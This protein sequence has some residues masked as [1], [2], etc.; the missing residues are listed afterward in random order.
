[1]YLYKAFG[2]HIASEVLIPQFI[3]AENHQA[4]VSIRFGLVEDVLRK[5]GR[6]ERAVQKSDK[7]IAFYF[8]KTGSFLVRNGN[9]IVVEPDSD[10]EDQLIRLPLIGIVM[11][12]LL[13]Q[14]GMF[15][16]HASAVS[17]NG[18]AVVFLG[19]KGAGKSTTAATLYKRGH[20]MISD[21]I[22][23]M[24][25]AETAVPLIESS[26]PNFKLMP[27]TAK[28][29]LGD[30][31]D[32]LSPVCTG[33]EKRFRPASD[34]FA[35][36]KQPLRAI[37]ALEDGASLSTTLLKPQEAVSTLIANTYLARYGK[38]LLQNNHAVK[39]LLECANIVN[40]IPVYRLERPRSFR[41]LED[42]ADLV[43]SQ[44]SVSSSAV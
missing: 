36:E 41:L 2:I 38:Q 16:L 27:E 3:N 6:I 21:D 34:N 42:L 14:R 43:E 40:R 4:D 18:E 17:I 29:I 23:A 39:N 19:W 44:C 28:S 1:M 24:D 8:E 26:F 31:P 33:I 13:H 12:G 32:S 7:E 22:V 10:A 5:D 20:P 30:D 9:E 25:A 11:A 37:Y 35:K 15:V